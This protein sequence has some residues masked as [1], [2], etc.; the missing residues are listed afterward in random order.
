MCVGCHGVENVCISACCRVFMCRQCIQNQK[1][2][3]N[4]CP[5]CKIPMSQVRWTDLTTALQLHQ[6]ISNVF[7]DKKDLDKKDQDKGKKDKDS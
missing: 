2:I 3:N 4:E 7:T 6:A 5:V 1:D